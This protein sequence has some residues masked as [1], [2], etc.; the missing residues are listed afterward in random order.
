[1]NAKNN[2]VVRMLKISVLR[3]NNSGHFESVASYVV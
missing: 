1:M 3:Q 2:S